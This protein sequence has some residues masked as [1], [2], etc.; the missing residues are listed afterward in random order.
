MPA[1][2][3]PPSVQLAYEFGHVHL[4]RHLWAEKLRPGELFAKMIR[5]IRQSASATP[6]IDAP[7]Y[8]WMEWQAEF[9]SGAIMVPSSRARRLVGDYCADRGL[10][11]DVPV[12]SHH[13]GV[14]VGMIREAFEVPKKRLG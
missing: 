1:T 9:V 6:S 12:W 8:D 7:S 2:Q 4:H 3:E 13:G 5:R 10:H 11:G 14:L